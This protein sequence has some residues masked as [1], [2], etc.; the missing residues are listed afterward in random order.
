MGR[1]QKDNIEPFVI[2]LHKAVFAMDRGIDRLL[3][4]RFELTFSQFFILRVLAKRPG[5]TQKAIAGARGLTEAAVSRSVDLLL[6]KRLITRKVN[7]A[8]RRE[9]ML[10][11]TK[12]GARIELRARS[13][14]LGKV[15]AALTKISA[16]ERK[17]LA[18][19]AEKLLDAFGGERDPLCTSS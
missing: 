11:L 13:A 2:A 8:N 7:P 1:S 9:H 15:D 10:V 14:A 18:R 4:E 6:G 17:T 16:A 19:A 3:A 5:T 12:E